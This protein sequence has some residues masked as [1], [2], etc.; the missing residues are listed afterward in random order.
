MPQTFAQGVI[1]GAATTAAAAAVI[2]AA[3]SL[4]ASRAVSA[5][6]AGAAS[7]T[8]SAQS[9]GVYETDKAVAEY[10][11]FHFGAPS[12]ILPYEPSV[13]P[14]GALDFASRTAAACVAWSRRAGVP[15]SAAFD[16]GCA[17]GRT[18]FDLSRDF[19]RVVGLDYSHAFVNA[20]AAL[21][22]S[23]RAEYACTVEGEVTAVKTVLVPAGVRSE[24]IK[25]VQGDAC[26]LPASD[27][28]GG[29]FSVIHAANLVC[30]LPDPMCVGCR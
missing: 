19:E 7:T 16:V 14:H 12:D 17:V 11:M 29:A 25:F 22:A 6:S 3:L 21:L 30:R 2:A 24:R 15:L 5:S 18:S 27:A 23:G 20:A 4:R 9:V 8:S 10:L 26:K 13:A 1:I 28:L